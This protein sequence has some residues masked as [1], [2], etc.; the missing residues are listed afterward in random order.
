MISKKTLTL[1]VFSF[2]M[3]VV[4][5]ATAAPSG[6][7]VKH[8]KIEI[9]GIDQMTITQTSDKAIINWDSFNIGKGESVTFKQPSSSSLVLNRVIGGDMTKI[10]G[11]LNANGN[12][13]LVNQAGIAISGG[14]SINVGGFLASSAGI[15]DNDFINA[16]FEDGTT[17][18][19]TD[20]T[21]NVEN[22]GVINISDGGFAVL[23]GARVANYGTIAV[24]LGTVHLASGT[25]F[26]LTFLDN[27]LIGFG[28]EKEIT[29]AQILNSGKINADGSIIVMT[30]KN[31]GDIMKN[32]INNTGVI[33]A[34]AI[35]KK[36]G[37]VHLIAD[38][39]S[40][41]SK[42]TVNAPIMKVEAV[43]GNAVLDVKG[44]K[45]LDINAGNVDIIGE[46]LDITLKGNTILKDLNNDGHSLQGNNV[47]ITSDSNISFFNTAFV[48]TLKI[49]SINF[50]FADLSSSIIGNEVSIITSSN[51]DGTGKIKADNV[52]LK[53]TTIGTGKDSS[54][55]IDA[56]KGRFEATEGVK[57][58]ASINITA[59]SWINGAKN[60]EFITQGLVYLNGK[61]TDT[62]VNPLVVDA[63]SR[64]FSPIEE[65]NASEFPEYKLLRGLEA[66]KD[67][68]ANDSVKSKKATSLILG[69]GI[70]KIR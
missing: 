19:F 52:Y 70:Y 41:I 34:G 4:N 16:D 13:F 21:K 12:V 63:E 68:L 43:G 2:M 69:D 9:S 59:S 38:G 11:S 5:F 17:Y 23:M 7:D 20:A 66:K 15:T 3:V 10:A 44:D 53:G 49:D 27:D 42:G 1:Q 39:G 29:D 58:V 46:N 6:S 22:S 25:D 32:V 65:T 35:N 18:K 37:E 45:K 50:K 55:F 48:Q 30:A 14:A 33:T 26:R 8:G 62:W 57:D 61:K 31:A 67:L 64:D 54:L 47:S 24:K 56:L 28:I 60:F 36:G 40:V 51:I